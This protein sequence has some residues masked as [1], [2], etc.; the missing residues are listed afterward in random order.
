[1]VAE[2]RMSEQQRLDVQKAEKSHEGFLV[3]GMQQQEMEQMINRIFLDSDVDGNGVLD[4]HVRASRDLM[5]GRGF[6]SFFG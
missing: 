2:M 1:M 6:I 5:L 4:R 3:K